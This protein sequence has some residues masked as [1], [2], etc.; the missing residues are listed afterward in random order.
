MAAVP[1]FG[2]PLL[3]PVT[4]LERG[5]KL[6]TASEEEEEAEAEEVKEGAEDGALRVGPCILVDDDEAIGFSAVWAVS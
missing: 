1:F 2:G 4:G 5:S 3:G 6:E